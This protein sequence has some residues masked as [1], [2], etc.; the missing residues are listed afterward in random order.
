MQNDDVGDALA[1][2]ASEELLQRDDATRRG[3]D[4]DDQEIPVRVAVQPI[5][6]VRQ[7]H[8]ERPRQY[9]LARERAFQSAIRRATPSAIASRS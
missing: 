1:R 3:A 8:C 2:D 7:E 5:H 9:R 4:A 6:L